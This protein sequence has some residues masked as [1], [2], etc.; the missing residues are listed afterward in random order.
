MLPCIWLTDAHI[1]LDAAGLTAC[2]FN[3]KKDLL[4]QL[5]AR[6]QQVTAN[7]REC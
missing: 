7:W 4:V 5:L 3:G 6:K 1:V 2:G